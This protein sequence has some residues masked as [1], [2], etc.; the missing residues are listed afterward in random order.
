[1]AGQV[2]RMRNLYPALRHT[3]HCSWWAS[4]I[5]PVRP[6]FRTY[7]IKLQYVRRYWIGDL[8]IINGYVPQ[9][10]LRDPALVLEH[11]R[12]GE[13]VPHVYWQ[14]DNPERSTLCL[15]DPA[16]DQWSPDE[17]LADT[18]VPWACEWLA[19]Y[20]GWLAIGEWTGG[21][22]HH[23]PRRRIA[24]CQIVDGPNRGQQDRARRDAFHSLGIKIGTFGSLPLMV[25]A[26]E[27]SSPLLSWLDWRNDTCKATPLP[28]ISI[29]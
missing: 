21:G 10:T 27:G 29:S 4:W 3:E 11:P 23:A 17:F 14:N 7:T 28:D 16:A 5:G 15:Y 13:P 25:A 8:E 6:V 26:S 1:M 20:E 18:I 2:A 12:T 19:C 22:R 24:S 9:V